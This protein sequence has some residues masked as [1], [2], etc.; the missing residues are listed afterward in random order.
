MNPYG[1]HIAFVKWGSDGKSRPVVILSLSSEIEA[2]EA[3]NP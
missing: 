3:I 2:L 1:L